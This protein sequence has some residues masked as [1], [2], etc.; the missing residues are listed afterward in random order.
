M[1]RTA[2]LTALIPFL[3]FGDYAKERMCS[4]LDAVRNIFESQ[5]APLEWKHSFS[6]WHLET[7]INQAKAEVWATPDISIK[8]YQLI[9]NR[10]FKS[11]QDY[12]VLVFFHSTEFAELPFYIKSAAGRYF[13]AGIDYMGID[14][15]RLQIGD[16]V[17]S[18]NG[19]PIAD[20]IAE[21]KKEF[22]GPGNELSDQA[23]IEIFFTKRT[24]KMG[25]R[26]PQGDV[27]LGVRHRNCKRI[28]LHT[29][30]WDYHPEMIPNV[31]IKPHM[32]ASLFDFVKKALDIKKKVPLCKSMLS[33]YKK[34][35]ASPKKMAGEELGAKCSFLPDLGKKIWSSY[36]ESSYNAYLFETP[37]HHRY[38]YIRIPSYDAGENEFWEFREIIDF[39]EEASEALVIDQLNNPGGNV[40]HMY[41]L[42][43][44]LSEKPLAI[45][46]QR[47]TLN[48][49]EIANAWDGLSLLSNV[50]SQDD[51]EFFIGDSLSG[52]PATVEIAHGIANYFRFLIDQWNL[53]I[54]FTAPYPIWGFD[55]IP[56]DS[57]VRYTKPILLL[58]N[59]LDF[60]CGDFFP[61]ILQDN[62]RATVMGTRTG[63]AGGFV[64]DAHYPNIFG[65]EAFTYTGS[66]AY[67]RDNMPIENL[68]VTPDIEYRITPE[69]LMHG[70]IPFRDNILKALKGI[71]P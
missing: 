27:V 52:M 18:F 49:E 70:Y 69:D 22:W 54:T 35:L 60:S 64:L 46:P 21:F 66:I 43:S 41:A 13:I 47:V 10:F 5:Y 48:Q 33:P 30:E 40:L 3:L 14:K 38:G 51:A 7:Q 2:C 53:G 28:S 11:T 59:E 55:V 12:H 31:P 23:V 19:Q 44:T 68:G 67:R 50:D 61:A 39:L 56:V 1:L 4:D 20:A 62:Q 6:G 71:T 16:E 15:P 36:S 63:G 24:G 26:V 25:H 45:P 58:V 65:V 34:M 9:L 57:K 8:D 17:I 29:F 32:E 37:D 42:L